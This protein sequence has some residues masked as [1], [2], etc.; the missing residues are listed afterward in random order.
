M[1]LLSIFIITLVSIPATL[2]AEIEVTARFNPPRIA[3]GDQAQY[4]I[5]VSETSADGQPQVERIT[6]LPIPQ[7]NQLKL[8]NGRTSNRQQT[9]IVNGN[10]E[11]SVTQSLIIDAAAPE[12]GNFSIPAYAFE[13]KGQRLQVPAATLEVVERSAD[14]GPTRDE[15]LFLKA[16]LPEKLYVGQ[17]VALDLKLYL[18]EDV[19]LRGLNSF[20]RSGDGFTIS[21][22]P[23]DYSEGVETAKGRRYRTL[24]WPLTLTPIRTGE[25]ELSFQFG[26]TARLPGEEEREADPLGRSP[27]GSSFFN[28]FFGRTERLNVYTD[29]LAVD[30]LPL[31]EAGRPESFSGGIGDLALEVGTDAEKVV[32]GEPVMLSV[33]LKGRGNFERI[34]GPGFPDSPEWRHYDPESQFEAS[35]T[36]GLSGSLRFDY[37]FIPQQAGELKLPETKFSYFDPEQE[38]YVELTAPPIPVE[39]APAEN[40]RPSTPTSP[41][42]KTPERDLQLSK[43]LTSEEALLTLDYRPKKPRPVGLG[44]LTNPLFIGLNLITGLA[45][46]G[47]GL[48]LHRNKRHREDPGYPVRAAA[49]QSLKEARQAYLEARRK[50]DAEAFYKH[51]QLAIRNAATLKTGHS[52]QSAHSSEIE[53]LLTGQAIEDCRSFFQ[54]ANAH[55]FGGTT[56]KALSEA[57]QQLERTLQAL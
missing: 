13:Y 15:L 23:E 4:I 19:R 35:D 38:E 36:L 6:S 7:T 55:R 10:A 46:L 37:V 20:D 57:Q 25:Q 1:R 29:S 27:L 8:S 9:R 28:N 21:E 50:D 52:M 32:Q 48:L 26:L 54:A 45:V 34:D 3:L 42:V 18:S 11:Y 5:E 33:V 16:E 41:A 12:T 56:R 39:V 14:A 2:L 43:S 17:M 44:I 22:L 40:N 49:R 47:G 30:V 24:T 51:G 31:P 53:A